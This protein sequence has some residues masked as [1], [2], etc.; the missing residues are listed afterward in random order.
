VETDCSS[1]FIITFLDKDGFRLFEHTTPVTEMAAAV[2]ADGQPTGL[3]WK[4]D[5]FKD[6]GL[7]RRATSWELSWSGFPPASAIEPTTSPATLIPLRKPVSPASPRWQD[8]SLWRG[9]SHGIS[10]DDVKRILGEPGKV[11]DLGFQV[12]WYYGYPSGGEVTFGK[13]G[14]VQS[15]SEP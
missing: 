9:L 11:S 13:D 12:T 4:G 6:V 5:E 7:Y 8:V 3:S 2:G 14:M 15:W 10:R 1:C